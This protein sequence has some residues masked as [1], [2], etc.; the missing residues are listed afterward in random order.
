MLREKENIIYDTFEYKNKPDGLP[1]VYSK[2]L[3]TSRLYQMFSE[4]VVIL[5]PMSFNSAVRKDPNF[6]FS[7]IFDSIINKKHITIGD[8]Y[9]FRDLVHPKFVVKQS[10]KAQNHQIIGSGRLVF[11]NDFIRD[12]YAKFGMHYEHWVTENFD[13]NQRGLRVTNYLDSKSCLYYYDELL[14][15]TCYDIEQIMKCKGS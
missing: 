1:Y 8:T 10:L 13:E 15:D 2:V 3:I 14:R 7:K 12:L 5:F 11:V 9:Y 6:L 4:K